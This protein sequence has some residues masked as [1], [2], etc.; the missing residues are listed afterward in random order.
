MSFFSLP[1]EFKRADHQ[2]SIVT[3]HV[4]YLH[5]VIKM[6]SLL[7]FLFCFSFISSTLCSPYV[8][9]PPPIFLRVIAATGSCPAETLTP[10]YENMSHYRFNFSRQERALRSIDFLKGNTRDCLGNFIFYTIS[11]TLHRNSIA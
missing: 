4:V 9:S 11:F 7:P 10:G 5:H 3:R 8:V 2:V 1:S 6:F